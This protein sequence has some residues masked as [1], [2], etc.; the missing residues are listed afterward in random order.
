MSS[1]SGGKA[2][3]IVEEF[4][5]WSSGHFPIR[6][7]QLAEGYCELGYD[8]DVLTSW[9]WAHPTADPPFTV[10]RLGVVARQF[11]RAAGHLR[12][13][14]GATRSRRIANTVGDALAGLTLA[15]AIRAHVRKMP[16]APEA[17]VVL[18]Y[19]T[20]PTLLASVVGQG[21]FILNMFC[22]PADCPRWSSAI[23]A[24]VLSACAVRAQRKR[25]TRGGR[26]RLAT[27]DPLWLPG[28]RA[29]AAYLDP[30]VLP[31]AG[32]RSFVRQPHAKTD[33][34]LPEGRRCALL[35]GS[36]ASK[37]LN[38]VLEA[39][40]GVDGWTLIVAGRVADEITETHTTRRDLVTL[41]GY[42]DDA[43]RDLLLSAADLI[44]LS[45][46]PGH[47][48]NS[49]TL[50]DAISAEVPVLCSSGSAA[51]EL[52]E[53]FR[54]GETFTP[55]DASSLAAKVVALPRESPPGFGDAQQ[56]LSNRNIAAQQLAALSVRP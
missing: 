8:V 46:E 12:S 21:R 3:L 13:A 19:F 48:R 1:N 4:A 45:F 30:V 35:F 20:E 39:F 33:L 28:W 17:V 34:G 56:A 52:V 10:H 55:G 2:A 29:S 32:T 49:G 36:E 23:C 22:A 14:G 54:L 6:F 50:M 18:G 24:R 27:A 9:G 40:D 42:V 11:R 51:S 26:F 16:R 41:P 25:E 38:A 44:V 53:R 31:I 47:R 15:V 5:H 7:A 37:D 43:T